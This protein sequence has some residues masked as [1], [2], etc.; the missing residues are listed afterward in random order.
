MC[1]IKDMKEQSEIE[2]LERM[3]WNFRAKQDNSHIYADPVPFP[4]QGL[5]WSENDSMERAKHSPLSCYCANKMHSLLYLHFRKGETKIVGWTLSSSGLTHSRDGETPCWLVI[6]LL[7]PV[8]NLSNRITT[9][10]CWKKG[11]HTL[12]LIAVL[13]V[14]VSHAAEP[15]PAWVFEVIPTLYNWGIGLNSLGLDK[16]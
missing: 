7:F 6:M 12:Q 3:L 1:K 5:V 13:L 14:S 4:L 2:C 15:P 11:S 16:L 8:F 10:S 9:N